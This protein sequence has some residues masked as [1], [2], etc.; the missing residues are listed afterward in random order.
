MSFPIGG[1]L[2]RSLYLHSPTVFEILRSK[3]IGITTHEFDLSRSRD[4][5]D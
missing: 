1:P 2:D 4:V 5:T 3:H